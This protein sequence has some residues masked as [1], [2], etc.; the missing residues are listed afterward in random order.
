A[1]TGTARIQRVSSKQLAAIKV[2]ESKK[3][4]I[5][6][7]TIYARKHISAEV[8]QFGFKDN[9]FVLLLSTA[10]TGY[11]ELVLKNRRRPSKT[12][13]NVKTARAPFAKQATKDL[14]IPCFIN[15]YNNNING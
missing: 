3:D 14:E 1:A 2:S 15:A 7:G 8:I 12:S 10:Y 4:S 5:P 9:A 13:S 11:E 6:W